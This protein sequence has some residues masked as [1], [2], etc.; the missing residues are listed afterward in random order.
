M[1]R[2]IITDDEERG[3]NT[4]A[5]MLQKY[6]PEVTVVKQCKNTSETKE[7]IEMLQPDL[8]FLDIHMPGENGIDFAK[9]YEKPLPPI[10]YV[11]AHDQYA[12]QA[13]KL[14][15]LDYLMKPLNVDELQEAINRYTQNHYKPKSTDENQ[16]NAPVANKPT[17]AIPHMDGIDYLTIEDIVRCE[18]DR[19]YTI[20]YL[21]N[22]QKKVASRNLGEY[23]EQLAQ[24]GFFRV[25]N[26]HLINIRHIIKYN[27]GRGGYL[28]LTGGYKIGIAQRRKSEF[29]LFLNEKL[30]HLPFSD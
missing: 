16:S 15:A 14:A 9:N 13:L 30:G 27:K 7:A 23:E 17:L 3:R 28:E 29:F 25:H 8:L 5:K 22:G 10:I 26:S 1:I 2:T 20:L 4:L 19:N 6:C 12:I 21:R 11:T 24:H 18:A